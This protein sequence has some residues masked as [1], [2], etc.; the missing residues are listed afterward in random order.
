MAEIMLDLGCP[1]VDY[2][3]STENVTQNHPIKGFCC[4]FFKKKPNYY[5]DVS[6]GGLL[7]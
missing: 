7:S 1:K 6:S 4:F 3:I 2:L 5:K